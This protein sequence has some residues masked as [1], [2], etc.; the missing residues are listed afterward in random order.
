MSEDISFK[1]SNYTNESALK[2]LCVECNNDNGFYSINPKYLKNTQNFVKCYNITAKPKNV[3]LNGKYYEPCYMSCSTCDYGGNGIQ[4]NCTSCATDYIKEPGNNTNCV[5][6]CKN[7]YYYTSYGQ[8]K[9]S[10]NM[11]CP[12]DK[13]LIIRNKNKCVDS[14]SIDETYKYQYNGECLDKC[15]DGTR[16]DNSGKICIVNNNNKCT[17]SSTKFDL[18]DFLKEGGVEKIAKTYAKEFEYTSKHISIFKNEVYSIMLYRKA[19]CITELGLPM[20]EIDFGTCYE[21]V[22]RNYSIH[23]P[24]LIA[25]IDKKSNK[26]NNPITSYSFYHPTTGQKLDSQNVCKE[27]VIIVKENIKSLLNN[28]VSDMDSLLFLTG[29]NIDI[30]NKSSGFYHDICYHFESPCDKD[31]ALNDRLLVYYPN[32]TLCDSG[33]TNS[34]VNLTTMTALCECKFKAMTD[35]ETEDEDYI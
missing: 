34:G 1:C 21:K 23:D 20:P 13:N 29:Q 26:K 15:P 28:S 2:G 30:F 16:L 5:I 32:I 9:C 12:E 11:Q 31:V 17:N 7:L 27:D 33:C 18:Y 3:Y 10:S 25:I 6:R 4:N 22:Q 8:Y 35:E 24:L 14:C 19:E